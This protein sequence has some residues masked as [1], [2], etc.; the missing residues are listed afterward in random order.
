MKKSLALVLAVAILLPV[1]SFAEIPDISNLSFSELLSLRSACQ[2]AMWECDDWQSVNVPAGVYKVGD[3][4]PAGKWTIQSA[5]NYSVLIVTGTELN[6]T[7]TRVK[8]ASNYYHGIIDMDLENDVN[9]HQ[10]DIVLKEGMYIS[11]SDGVVFYPFN[12]PDFTFNR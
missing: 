2:R 10:L 1:V 3:E 9:P 7:E 5:S 8:G 12:K 6:E 4:I 11:F